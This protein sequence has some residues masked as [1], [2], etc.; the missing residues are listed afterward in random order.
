MDKI[1]KQRYISPQA[2]KRLLE[3]WKNT[4]QSVLHLEQ[5]YRVSKLQVDKIL[6]FRSTMLLSIT[7]LGRETILESF[8]STR[9]RCPLDT[10][11]EIPISNFSIN[12][13]L[14]N[15]RCP[16]QQEFFWWALEAQR[17]PTPPLTLRFKNLSV[18]P[19]SLNLLW[20][21]KKHFHFPMFRFLKLFICP[22]FFTKHEL[23]VSCFRQRAK[24]RT[25]E[26]SIHL[27]LELTRT[28]GDWWS[29]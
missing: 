10:C 6:V 18:V 3:P 22:F 26:R 17:P 29:L 8:S 7:F 21:F 14:D 27:H 15:R 4:V 20:G 23:T 11:Q 12:K 19:V 16:E 13:V 25:S 1:S 2:D 9:K 5:R 28:G 24:S